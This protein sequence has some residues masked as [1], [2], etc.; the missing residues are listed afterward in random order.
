M[1]GGVDEIDTA[2]RSGWSVLAVGRLEAVTDYDDAEVRRGRTLPL[3][4]W[5]RGDRPHRL[6][7]VP[8][9]LTGR[10]VGTGPARVPGREDR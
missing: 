9:R 7:L 1:G 6:R 8:T 4:P 3:F 5:P 10:R 2:A